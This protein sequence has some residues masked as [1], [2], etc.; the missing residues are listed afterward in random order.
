MVSLRFWTLLPGKLSKGEIMS[1]KLTM[2]IMVASFFMTPTVAFAA[3]VNLTSDG[4]VQGGPFKYL[5]ELI[6][7]IQLTPGQDVFIH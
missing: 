3:D 5:Q 7:N 2:L 6:D 4:K 1:K